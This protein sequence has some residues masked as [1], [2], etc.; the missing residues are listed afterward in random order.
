[1]ENTH[2]SFNDTSVKLSRNP[3][4]IIALFI[5]LVYG[6]AGLLLGYS[7][8]FLS[9]IERL[10]MIGFLVFFPLIVLIVFYF[11]VTRHNEKL[12]SPQDFRTD[13]AFFKKASPKEQAVKLV[14][15]SFETGRNQS[16]NHTDAPHEVDEKEISTAGQTETIQNSQNPEQFLPDNN[17]RL[18]AQRSTLE[19][20]AHAE[21]LALENIELKYRTLVHRGYKLPN[22]Y[23]ADGYFKDYNGNTCLVEVKFIESK[24]AMRFIR[25]RVLPRLFEQ[26][27]PI[28]YDNRIK[29]ILYLV[30]SNE[31]DENQIKDLLEETN[32]SYPRMQVIVS[33]ISEL[34]K[35]NIY[36]KF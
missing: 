11:L 8:K 34:E 25:D 14:E 23:V 28:V 24:N 17:L 5:V 21:E 16:D 7:I 29:V 30:T 22:G 18:D 6:I 20:V 19:R 3:L 10:L 31:L 32:N 4:G 15:E 12:Y 27:I 9:Y 2:K 33:S 26:L 36:M 35:K 1:M 13:D